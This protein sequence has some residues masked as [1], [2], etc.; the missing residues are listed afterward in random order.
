MDGPGPRQVS[1][2]RRD[3]RTCA[4]GG[5]RKRGRG[6]KR[7]SEQADRQE[8]LFTTGTSSPPF[9]KR[10][11]FALPPNSSATTYRSRRMRSL[12][13]GEMCSL[14]GRGSRGIGRKGEKEGEVWGQWIHKA[15]GSSTFPSPSLP[16]SLPSFRY[17]VSSSN[18]K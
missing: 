14:R 4:R 18:L 3:P 12:A 15:R 16:S 10:P 9:Q 17:Q 8:S 5:G 13:S 2:G 1:S 11:P 7:T 6:G